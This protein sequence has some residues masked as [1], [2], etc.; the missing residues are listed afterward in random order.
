MVRKGS[1]VRVR[2]RALVMAAGTDPD[3][4]RLRRREFLIASAAAGLA[5]SGPVNYAALARGRRLPFA[6]GGAFAHGVA[7][8]MP[9]P[10]SITLWTRVSG[11][12]RS[13]RLLL[14]V[15]TD[16][17]FANVVRRKPVVA[18]RNRD[19]TVHAAVR[20]L[21]P[22]REYFYRFQTRDT[23]SRVGR[24]RTAPPADSRQ[25]V[26]I[27]FYSCQ[28]YEAGFYTALAGLAKEP[29]LDLVLCLGDYIYEFNFYE[30][31]GPEQRRDRS[32]RNRDGEVQRL[33]E[34]RQKYRLYQRDPNLQAMHARHPFLAIWDDH[35]VEDNY[36]GDG[37]DSAQDDPSRTN[38]DTPRS[39]PFG[40]RRRNGYRAFFEAMPRRRIRGDGNRIYGPTRLGGLCE[41]FL[42][43]QRQYRDPQSCG[44]ELAVPCPEDDQPGRTML[45]G[46]QKQW[47]KSA[48]RGSNAQW[49]LLANQLMLM[50]LDSAP[51]IHIN[52]DQWDGYSAERAELM[53]FV[54][55]NGIEDLVALT[56]D[57]HTFFAGT[58]T[59]TG[60]SAGDPVGT[61]FVGGSVTSPGIPETLG[62]P[63]SAS[64]LAQ[65][66][67]ANNP[68]L[69]YLDVD[70]RG[71]GVISLRPGEATVEF[72][73]PETTMQPRSPVSQLARF[74]VAA[75]TP[76]AEQV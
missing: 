68:H 13:S 46:R 57:I 71:Y 19:F 32:G 4:G 16:R 31:D 45:G 69:S 36:A 67:R 12:E 41:L 60:N 18:Q 11:L 72:K 51:G 8:G 17:R 1:P 14:E 30:E 35:E 33:S 25:P 40:Q 76:G 48:L 2:L 53:G 49:K 55:D 54:R 34:Y 22:H 61:E 3:G 59:T 44:D 73:A 15:A 21:A 58:V 64:Q 29:D 66:L 62:T 9:A 56:G 70:E 42:L 6:R 39:V 10:K 26:R 28:S 20:G 74:R 37:A 5:V 43:D 63:G 27:G 7:A 75:G 52:R 50:S 23:H 47:L 65:V 38:Q 24:F